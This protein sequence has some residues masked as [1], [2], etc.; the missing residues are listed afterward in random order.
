MTELSFEKKIYFWICTCGR[1]GRPLIWHKCVRAGLR[2]HQEHERK[3]EWNFD[4]DCQVALDVK[5][6]VSA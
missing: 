1:K 3:L 5:A 2:H 4:F 6:K